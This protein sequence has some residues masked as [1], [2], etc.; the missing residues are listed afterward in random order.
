MFPLDFIAKPFHSISLSILQAAQSNLLY[1]VVVVI[2]LPQ[3]FINN[4]LYKLYNFFQLD[5]AN[6]FPIDILEI[7]FL[8]IY[9]AVQTFRIEFYT[10]ATNA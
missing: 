8:P 9:V 2:I 3:L 5:T 6:Y 10:R 4:Q 7:L 1:Q